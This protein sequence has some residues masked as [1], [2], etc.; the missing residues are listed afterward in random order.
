MNKLYIIGTPIGNLKDITIRALE[1]LNEINIILCEDTRNSLKLLNHYNIKN[2]KLISYHKFNEKKISS[3]ILELFKKEK[4]IALISDAG[5]PKISD[6]GNILI[7]KCHELNIN[8][9]IIPGPTAFS[10]SYILSPF[11]GNF[12]FLGFLKDK[13]NQRQKELKNLNEGIYIAYVSPYKLKK[14]LEDLKLIFENNIEVFLTKEMTKL[15]EKYYFGTPEKI[16][17]QLPEIIKGEYTITFE[18]KSLKI[19]KIKENK[20]KHLV[21]AK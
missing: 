15:Y 5:M 1:T 8:V 18:I 6:P 14:T 12:T 19:K 4:K 2:K 21:K 7:K 20:Y 13:S 16:L 3:F 11:E 9:E 10:S 17:E